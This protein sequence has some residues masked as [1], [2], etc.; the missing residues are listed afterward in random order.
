MKV[1]ATK[2]GFYGHKRR[3]EGDV[4]ELVPYKVQKLDAEGKV[5]FD[6][7]RKPVLE[8]ISPEAQFSDSWMSRIEAAPRKGKHAPKAQEP[9][10]VE[11]DASDTEQSSEDDVI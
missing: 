9:E 11:S 1:K 5:V 6:D 8:T 2:L 3:R 10:E 7:K 4:F